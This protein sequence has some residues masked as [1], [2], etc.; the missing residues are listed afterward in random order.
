METLIVEAHAATKLRAR[1]G[2]IA[3]LRKAIEDE[4]EAHMPGE[5]QSA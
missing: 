2:T 5:G 1:A 4:I 3:A